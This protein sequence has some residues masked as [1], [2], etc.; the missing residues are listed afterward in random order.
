MSDL[1]S[2]LHKLQPASLWTIASRPLLMQASGLM[3]TGE[4]ADW[5]W[6][7]EGQLE[8]EFPQRL[9]TIVCRLRTV[10]G[11]GLASACDCRSAQPCQHHLAS[12]MLAMHLLKD[13]NAFG[14]FPNRVLAERL[15]LKLIRVDA[16][17][18]R[19]N[20]RSREPQRH[21]IIRPKSNQ[22]FGYRVSFE[23]NAQDITATAPREVGEFA[24]AWTYTHGVEEKFWQWF[25]GTSRSLPVFMQMEDGVKP[26]RPALPA[27]IYHG[28]TTLWIEEGVVRLKQ[29][30]RRNGAAIPDQRIKVGFG[31]VYLVESETLLRLSGSSSWSLLST[32]KSDL[33]Q[34]AFGGKPV[35]HYRTIPDGIEVD[36]E[37]WN[38]SCCS[39][40]DQGKPD[41][42]PTLY[43]EG[44]HIAA[45]VDAEILPHIALE[46]A[47]KEGDLL[48]KVSL[49]SDQVLI[50]GVNDAMLVGEVLDHHSPDPQL[51]TA[52]NRREVIL[53]AI[54]RCWLT[55]DPEERGRILKEVEDYPI[56]RN[57]HQGRLAARMVSELISGPA[58][59]DGSSDGAFLCACP[60][61]GWIRIRQSMK[62][63]CEA[64]ALVRERLGA[65]L[66]FD[67][68]FPTS[69]FHAEFIVPVE[70]AFLR[71][72]LLVEECRARGIRLTYKAMPVAS[73]SLQMRVNADQSGGRDWFELRSEVMCGGSLIP[74][75]RW[76]QILRQ[77][78][79]I[80]ETGTLRV[81]DVTSA[82][83][84][85]RMS[86]LLQLQARESGSRD[87]DLKVPRL[88]ILDW[89]E[90]RK[91]GV[92]CDIP[93][94]Q[95]PVL[96]SLLTFDKLERVPL[97]GVRAKLREYQHDGY[98]W[99]A[100]H[101]RHGFGACLA[102]DMGLGK[103]LQ[104]I[105]LMA[106]IKEG[107]VTNL[108]SDA[109]E[110]R[111]HLLVVPP[112]LLFN[113]QSE[114]RNFFPSLY[115]HEYT[116]AGRSLIGIHEGVV[117]T[118]YDLVRRDI[119]KLKEKKFDCIIF[120]EAQAV[121]NI[122]GERAR[123]MRQ[124]QGR[125]K[126]VLTGTPLEN[127]A[128]EYFSI[129][130]LALPGLLGE[131]KEFLSRVK[132]P[133]GL[134]NPLDRARPFV[135][136]RTKEKILTELPPKVE[137]DIHLELTEEQKRFYTRAVAEVRAE[138][139][140]AF[141]DKTAQQAGIVA[142]AALTRLRQVC[143]SPALIDREYAECSPK[144]GYLC[145]K[146]DELQ[147]EGHAA[148]VFSQFTKALDHLEIHLKE[149]GISYQ[150]LDGSTPQDKRK[151]L[152][153]AYQNASGPGVFLI[154]LRAGGAGL[155]LTRASYVFHLDPWWNPA[156]E[157]QAS[158]RAHRMGQKSTVFIQ[159]LLMLH[160]VEE[161]IMEL[162]AQKRAL[163]DQVMAG[164]TVDS[165]A[166]GAV[167]TKDDLRFLLG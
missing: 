104:T 98:S 17:S 106:A 143:V 59:P 57:S 16:R 47:T 151:K 144:L 146:L 42:L 25:R 27:D 19:Q 130:D 102:D 152:V 10:E 3:S 37:R 79:Y 56:F 120:D 5:S 70:K 109:G 135:L 18:I 30:L 137:S 33:T 165:S 122:L 1:L 38:G 51:T 138:V 32:I 149:A 114:V 76:E 75:E 156:V 107:M 83:G 161:K 126:L 113:W 154:S 139:L 118:T 121:K 88:R 84:L 71:L 131:R 134:F 22:V 105:T 2:K 101:Y 167:I 31:M 74:Q 123:A 4:I 20:E 100:F 12:L 62:R 6:T 60:Q 142:L 148:L 158:D 108:A 87:G 9:N 39:W 124:L 66:E 157:N 90:L 81:I 7:G 45:P 28:E 89:L 140:E 24:S 69:P 85:R 34:S 103:T 78:H 86:H 136:R 115:V 53:S 95:R 141:A 54:H 58:L 61:R 50:G 91:H 153:E 11:G 64:V 23:S 49:Q 68:Y 97:P 132:E 129:I 35:K 92:Q 13:F 14:R 15:H 48:V 8:V 94:E 160:T 117:L 82:E 29:R 162:K 96:E 21:V 163:F 166:A 150:R 128:G 145:G 73:T 164:G 111:P 46:P 72:P 159:R 26:V 99:L 43:W 112:T 77:G 40:P 41:L 36:V 125:F 52:R 93:E 119:E 80:D 116:G 127:H 44:R 133:D 65:S 63:A 110:R 155:N 67:S 55:E 147:E